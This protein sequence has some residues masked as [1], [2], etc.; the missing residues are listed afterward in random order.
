VPKY[1]DVL[2]WRAEKYMRIMPLV[3]TLL[4]YSVQTTLD[5]DPSIAASADHA[6]LCTST[7]MRARGIGLQ[8]MGA[9]LLGGVIFDNVSHRNCQFRGVPHIQMSSGNGRR[10]PVKSVLWKSSPLA[11]KISVPRAIWRSGNIAPRNHAFLWLSWADWCGGAGG[12][13]PRA[14][15]RTSQ[16]RATICSRSPHPHVAPLGANPAVRGRSP[17][18]NAIR[19][20]GEANFR[21]WAEKLRT[22]S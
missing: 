21:R 16:G 5:S 12:W 13:A 14:H 15:D 10:L 8:G 2:P 6:H 1:Q 11:P 17:N 19:G 22:L 9:V 20:T 7:G 3:M 4:L 18:V